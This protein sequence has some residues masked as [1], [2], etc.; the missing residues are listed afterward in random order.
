MLRALIMI[1]LALNIPCET[2]DA[3]LTYFWAAAVI[4]CA[5]L[6]KKHGSSAESQRRGQM[7][8]ADAVKGA[9]KQ[10]SRARAAAG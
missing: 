6:Q 9:T 3:C 1:C 8:A 7:A 10:A 2:Y 5:V 4:V